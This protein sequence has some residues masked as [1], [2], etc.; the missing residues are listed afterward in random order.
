MEEI[1]FRCAFLKLRIPIFRILED[2]TPKG[3]DP[4]NGR[5]GM[6]YWKILVLGTLRLGCNT[7]YDAL[8]EIADQHATVRRMMGHS[9][10]D[11]DKYYP[12]QTIK[13][14][15]SLL[16]PE[17]MAR[18][19]REVV[20]HGHSLP[21]KTELDNFNARCDSY[22]VETNVHYP[23]DINLLL[24]A[25]GKVIHLIGLVCASVGVTDWRQSGHNKRKVKK[26]YRKVQQAKRSN[27]K[28]PKKR[29]AKEELV[30]EAYFAYMDTSVDFLVKTQGTIRKIRMPPSVVQ[31][32][33]AT[34]SSSR[35][36]Y[37]FV[38]IV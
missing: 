30:R 35:S 2:L 9:I 7:N 17:V 26:L 21:G 3:I 22:V 34:F 27:S 11:G 33:H 6:E 38:F 20:K 25:M 1:L 23:T 31:D 16:T 5:T 10:F 13:D 36:A 12:L 32:P 19:S 14:N 37:S 18:I 24:D 15:L 8:K 28:D 29:A 4:G